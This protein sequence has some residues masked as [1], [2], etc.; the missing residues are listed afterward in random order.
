MSKKVIVIGGGPA[1]YAA[2][3]KAS[4]LGAEVTLAEDAGIGGTCLNVGC[5]PTKSLL[6]TAGFYQLASLNAVAGVNITG[7]HLDWPA[8][9][10]KKNETVGRLSRGVGALLRHNGVTVLSE[11]AVPLS[12]NKVMAGGETLAADAVILATGSKNA[13]LEFPGAGLPGVIDSTDALSLERLPASVVIVG[14]GVIGVEFATLF[15]S[16][17][18]KTSVIE[19]AARLLPLMDPEISGYARDSLESCGVSVHTGARLTGAQAAQG[20]LAVAF[21]DDTGPQSIT[22]DNLLVAV[23]RTPNTS[24]LGLEDIGV[25]LVRGAVQTDEYYRT[26]VPSLYAVGDCNGSTMLAHAAMAQGETAAGHIMGAA[27]EINN[28]TVPACI[29]TQ[30]EIA[31]VGMTGDQAAESGT[32]H[33]VGRFDLSGTAKPVSKVTADLSRSLPANDSAI[34]WEST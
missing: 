25:K 17:G 1:G 18:V 19:I 23:G 6:H 8:A 13:P 24:G 29:F 15:S 11:K 10:A 26:D 2:A 5:I 28:K 3:I 20:G 14:G 12:G 30:P 31:A 27:P 32:D 4:Q 33:T 21:S 9:L 22:A 16:L 7:A 34:Y